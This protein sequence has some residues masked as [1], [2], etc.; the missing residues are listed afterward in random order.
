MIIKALLELLYKVFS[1]LTSAISIPQLPEEVAGFL[2][3]FIGYLVTGM[4][5][6]AVFTHFEYLLLLIG[7]VVAID[8]GMLIYHFVMWVIKKIPMLGIE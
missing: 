3:E 1:T 7:I 2:E 4:Q 8:V 5:I 6:L